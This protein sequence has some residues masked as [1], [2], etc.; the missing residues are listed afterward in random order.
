MLIPVYD[1]FKSITPG[2]SKYGVSNENGR[3]VFELA[4]KEHPNISTSFQHGT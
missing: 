2:N 1:N 3:K 4:T